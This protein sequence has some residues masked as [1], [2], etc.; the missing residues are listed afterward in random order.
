MELGHGVGASWNRPHEVDSKVPQLRPQLRPQL[1]NPEIA[2]LKLRLKL[3]ELRRELRRELRPSWR[4]L[5]HPIVNFLNC[6]E[7]LF[8]SHNPCSHYYHYP[9]HFPAPTFL[10]ITYFG[11]EMSQIN[12][13]FDRFWQNG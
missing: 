12:Q 9:T 1:P 7:N 2:N 4:S 5:K 8:L 11:R 6:G 13:N 3:P 10:S